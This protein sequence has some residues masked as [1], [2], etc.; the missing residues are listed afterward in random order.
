MDREVRCYPD[1]ISA[2]TLLRVC[3]IVPGPL[4]LGNLKPSSCT[5]RGKFLVF[6]GRNLVLASNLL[7]GGMKTRHP[8][9]WLLSCSS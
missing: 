5:Q 2:F 1:R 4:S 9:G 6:P 8:T 3:M 7:L